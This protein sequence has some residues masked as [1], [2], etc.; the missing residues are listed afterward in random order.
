[1]GTPCWPHDGPISVANAHKDSTPLYQ[2]HVGVSARRLSLRGSR[3]LSILQLCKLGQYPNPRLLACGLALA[4][5]WRVLRPGGDMRTRLLPTALLAMCSLVAPAFCLA[6]QTVAAPASGDPNDQLATI[7]GTVVSANTG[8]PL[9][10]AHVVLSLLGEDPGEAGDPN[11]QAPTATT[12]AAG[13][14]SIDKIPAGKYDLEVTR[15]DYVT[16]RYGQDQPD[17]P[18]AT[19]TLAP[20]HKIADLLFR[21]NRMG[22]ITGRVLDEDGDPIRGVAVVSMLHRTAGGK[23]KIDATGSDRTN[24]RGEYRIVDLLPGRYSIVATPPLMP[25][26]SGSPQ[27]SDYLPT[28]Y[29]GTTDSARASTIEVKSGDELSG[30]DFAFSPKPPSRTYKVRGHV[31]NALTGNPDANIVVLLFPRGNREPLFMADQKKGFADPKTGDFEI[32]DVVSGEYVATAVSFAGSKTRTAMQNVDVIATD[33]DGVSLVLTRGADIPVRITLEGKSAGSVA[34]IAVLLEPSEETSMPFNMVRAAAAQ[35]DGSFVLKEIGDGSY[36]LNVS[37]KCREC[38]LKSAKA[39][40]V[41]LLDQGVQISSGAGPGPIAIVYSSNT[42]T[43]TGAVTNKDDLPAP[44]A[45]VVLVPDAG[46]HQKPEQYKTANTDQYGHFE[47]RGVPPGHYKAFAWEKVN[48]ESYGDPDFLKPVENK[49][50][51]FDIAANEQKSVQLKMIPASDS[52]N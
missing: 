34:D 26:M 9:K 40:G 30:I 7:A 33:V 8:E 18:G 5:I 16:A 43:L 39:N 10:K 28:Y 51:S 50:E 19:L 42:A 48:Q 44:G 14:F 13:H 46:S 17:K 36:S 3:E 11:K 2:R 45:M 23:P 38:Y 15:T 20:G 32:K 22:V 4:V 31:L 35:P 27:Q 49:S 37:S 29:S 41:D 12:D 6:Q 52:A 47:V 21:L 25:T 1:M 24:D